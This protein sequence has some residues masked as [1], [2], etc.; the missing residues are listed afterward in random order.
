LQGLAR[1]TGQF[2]LN[3][4][5]GLLLDDGRTLADP[6]ADLDIFDFQADQV[7]AL[8]LLSIARLNN[9]RSRARS[10][11]SSRARIDHT[12]FGLRGR[13]CPISCPLFQGTRGSVAVLETLVVVGMAY[14]S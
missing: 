5:A 10:S 7:A 4:P 9:A 2:E 3:R 1:A 6:P 13:F 8:S 11:I 14:H 12:S